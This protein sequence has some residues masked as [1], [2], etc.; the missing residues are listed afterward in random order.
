M[1]QNNL[2]YRQ[3][4]INNITTLI[5]GFRKKY[6]KVEHFISYSGNLVSPR[7]AKRR[8]TLQLYAEVLLILD[9]IKDNLSCLGK[10][11]E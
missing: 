5:Y 9:R 2:N 7:E 8:L 10:L 6:H 11:E 1:N 4:N 3:N